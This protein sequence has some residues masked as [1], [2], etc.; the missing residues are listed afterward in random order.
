MIAER[1][2]LFKDFA[3]KVGE[4]TRAIV[5]CEVTHNGQIAY[6]SDGDLVSIGGL[7]SAASAFFGKSSNFQ[8]QNQTETAG[9]APA[10][11]SPQMEL[12][13]EKPTPI[14]KGKKK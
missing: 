3:A 4:R 2:K 5:V 1:E 7:I 13:L 12:P 14:E 6:F 9:E 8:L 10:A 11:P